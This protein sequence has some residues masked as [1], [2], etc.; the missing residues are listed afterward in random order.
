[1]TNTKHLVIC[2]LLIALSFVG[3][4]L[5]VFG[6][7]AFDSMPAFVAA[8]LLG[9]IYGAIIGFI[10][11]ILTALLSGFPLSPPLHIVIAFAMAITMFGFGYTYK[12]LKSR[13]HESINLSITG[14]IGVLLNGPFSLGLSMAVLAIMTGVEAALSLTALLPFLML[15]TIINVV[16]SILIFKAL[17]GFWDKNK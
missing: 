7:I 14:I 5:R 2:A 16:L 8:L 17:Q 6:S 3:A 10:G 13:M 12:A 15:A 4:N 9:P 1:M 11:H